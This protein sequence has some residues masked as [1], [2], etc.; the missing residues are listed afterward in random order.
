MRRHHLW[1]LHMR[2]VAAPFHLAHANALRQIALKLF[3]VARVEDRVI[4]AP[5]HKRRLLDPPNELGADLKLVPARSEICDIRGDPSA[6]AAVQRRDAQ[7]LV[8]RELERKG[9]GFQD[10]RA[11]GSEEGADGGRRSQTTPPSP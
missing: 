9:E 8:A 11:E 4:R 7:P 3:R 2:R 6:L 10:R 5:H 1:L